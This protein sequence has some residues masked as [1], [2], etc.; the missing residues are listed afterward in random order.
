M[1]LTDVLPD[2]WYARLLL[3]RLALVIFAVTGALVALAEWNILPRDALVVGAPAIIA[4]LL[5]DT[6]LFNEFL[7]RTGDGFWIILYTF[8]YLQAVITAAV[9]TWSSQIWSK[10][11]S[12]TFLN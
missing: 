1:T 10:Y 3:G 6:F 4:T 12:S 5:L 11:S 9:V 7:I 8:L 2:K